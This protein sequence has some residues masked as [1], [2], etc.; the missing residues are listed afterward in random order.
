MKKIKKSF[1]NLLLVFCL[2]VSSTCVF[3]NSPSDT[4]IKIREFDL[5]LDLQTKSEAELLSLGYSSTEI[6]ELYRID[7]VSLLLERAN[8][9]DYELNQLGYAPQNIKSLREFKNDYLASP[10]SYSSLSQNEI[11]QLSI[12]SPEVTITLR[13]PQVVTSGREWIVKLDWSW[14][15]CPAWLRNDILAFSWKGYNSSSIPV[16]VFIDKTST[17]T[18]HILNRFSSGIVYAPMT[19]KDVSANVYSNFAMKGPDV[20]SDYTT[21]GSFSAHLYSDVPV[22]KIAIGYG[23]GHSTITLSPSVDFTGT[24]GISFGS[25]MDDHGIDSTTFNAR[26]GK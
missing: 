12:L 4:Q 7:L 3:A 22:E 8:L 19:Y 11:N 6:T 17:F 20:G 5:I 21:G 2:L 14:D 16:G 26:T 13:S 24:V 10:K 25:G 1:L 18:Y 23:Y 9:S 15:Y